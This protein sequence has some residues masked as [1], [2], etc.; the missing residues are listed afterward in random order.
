MDNKP[1]TGLHEKKTG[2]I[3]SIRSPHTE[4]YYIG[5]TY[6]ALHKRFYEH[7][8]GYLKNGPCTSKEILK[9]GD[10]YIEV[11]EIYEDCNRYLLSKR[12]HE[13]IRQHKDEVVNLKGSKKP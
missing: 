3:Y 5:S 13:L 8:N 11:M 9:Y 2:Y 10:A 12:E 6:Q 4:K 1:R 7:K